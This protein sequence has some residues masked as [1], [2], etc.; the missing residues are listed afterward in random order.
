MITLC[1]IPAHLPEKSGLR[2]L[3][4]RTDLKSIRNRHASVR[5]A[6]GPHTKGA[7]VSLAPV[8]WIDTLQGD[9][10]LRI[11]KYLEY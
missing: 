5:D 7:G 6:A 1:I 2:I 11:G 4:A 3:P 8:G 10:T 9:S